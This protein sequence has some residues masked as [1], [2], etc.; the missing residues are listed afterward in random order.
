[1]HKGVLKID[2]NMKE[3]AY[4][5]A[6]SIENDNDDSLDELEQL[7]IAAN[8]IVVAK[9]IQNREKIEPKTYIG[10]GKAKEIR[11][12]AKEL[13]ADVIIFN[14]ELSGSQ[15]KNLE[16]IIEKKIIDRTDLILD[17]FA[18]RAQSNEGKLQVKLAQLEYRLPRLIG[19]SDYLSREG[20]GIGTRGPGEQKLET[21]RRHIKREIDN[22]KKKLK[23]IRLNRDIKRS[24]RSKSLIPLVSMIGYTN[25]GK[26]TL[27]NRLVKEGRSQTK[28]QLY[29]DDMLFATLDT[30]L[31]S[32]NLPSGREIILSD[33]VGFVSKLPTNLVEA[34]KGTLEEIEHSDLI[35]IV[36][37]ISQDNL[38]L[39][40]QTTEKMLDELEIENIPIIYVFNKIDKIDMED[41]IFN[42]ADKEPKVFISAKEDINIDRLLETIEHILDLEKQKVVLHFPYNSLD[43]LD[44]L[45]KIYKADSIE[46]KDDYVLVVGNLDKMGKIRYE[47]YMVI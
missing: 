21:D 22:I 26:S 4:L 24:R 17:I 8:L 42:F 10:S 27:M 28:A 20:G 40:L 47:K 14:D 11:D 36:S 9:D 12:L 2:E 34:F 39:Q 38:S 5:I 45:L 3:K 37:D 35:L 18:K 41:L 1:M 23:N 16:K 32:T 15:M 30:S 33:T 31:R 43:E 6:L 29:A 25:A 44:Y 7:A 13:E 19:Y 46:Y